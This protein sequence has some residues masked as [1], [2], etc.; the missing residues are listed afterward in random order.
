IFITDRVGRIEWVNDAFCRLS[1]Y[2]REELLGRSPGIFGSGVDEDAADDRL[3][4][5][6]REGRVWT[7][8]V[9]ARRKGGE[10]YVVQETITPL[11]GH[12]GTVT[13]FVA[14]HEDVTAR[15]R[16]EEQVA[17]QAFH[18]TLTGLANRK[19]FQ[20][21]LPEEMARAERS[22]RLL[23][24]HFLDLDNFKVVNDSLGHAAGDRLLCEVA[25]RLRACIRSTDRVARLGG[26]EFAVLQVDLAP[27]D[28]AAALARKVL[29]KLAAPFDLGEHQ[30][31]PR[32]SVGIT[33]YPLD[34]AEPAKLLQNADMAMYL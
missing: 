28:G 30:V 29:A 17:F 5:T 24:V 1:G 22:G 21:R 34:R 10:S 9:V 13:H 18:D 3:R 26:D 14:I 33:V 8:E 25:D 7:G 12:D 31:Q 23:A 4:T 32:G 16:A 27:P 6:V 2:A 15:K 20:E 11:P 19:Q